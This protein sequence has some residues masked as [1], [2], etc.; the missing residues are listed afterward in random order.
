[1]R[2]A[3]LLP[4]LSLGLQAQPDALRYR[5]TGPANH[6]LNFT[7]SVRRSRPVELD[8]TL[9]TAG[10][11]VP[12]AV[13]DDARLG[14][15]VNRIE[16]QPDARVWHGTVENE[17]ASEVIIVSY[18][19]AISGHILRGEGRT[20]ELITLD[21]TL[22]LRE[23]APRES[24]AIDDAI[25]LSANL[26]RHEADSCAPNCDDGFVVDVLVAYSEQLRVIRGGKDQT[27]ALVREAIAQTNAAFERS[28][29]QT[30]LRLVHSLEVQFQ[31]SQNLF[32][33][34]ARLQNPADGFL[35]ELHALRRHYGAD[36]VSLWSAIGDSSAGVAYLG[37]NT[38]SAADWAFSVVAGQYAVS[39]LTFAHEIGHNFGA[40]HDHLNATS[41]PFVD[42]AYGYQGPRIASPYRTIMAYA[43]TGYTCDR[44][45][46]F[47]NLTAKYQNQPIGD[48]GA[49]NAR[50]FNQTRFALARYLPTVEAPARTI[51]VTPQ[52]TEIPASG[53]AAVIT[54]S[55]DGDWKA[56]S[57]LPWV[58]A[59]PAV[60]TGNGRVLLTVAANTAAASR[61]GVVVIGPYLVTV[62]QAGSPTAA[63]PTLPLAADTPTPGVLM[64]CGTTPY[65][66]YTFQGVAGQQ[67]AV[68][69]TSTEFDPSLSISGPPGYRG[70]IANSSYFG[71]NDDY[72]GGT[73]SR[74]PES[75]NF[76]GLPVS[77]AYT[78]I[79]VAAGTTNRGRFTVTV[80]SS[81]EYCRYS[82]PSALR[83]SAGAS[84]FAISVGAAT[85]CG[86]NLTS[87]TGWLNVTLPDDRHGPASVTLRVEPNPEAAARAAELLLT[88]GVLT[89][90]IRI[91][92]TQAAGTPCAAED[93][94][95]DVAVD[96]TIG[97]GACAS[98]NRGPSYPSKRYSVL[99]KAGQRL[100]FAVKSGDFEPYLALITASGALIA[101]S[102]QGRLGSE[103]APLRLP[104][105]GLYYLEVSGF[106]PGATGR[107]TVETN[108]KLP[109]PLVD[110]APL[111]FNLPNA[112]DLPAVT[113]GTLLEDR[114][115]EFEV[116]ANATRLQLSATVTPAAQVGLHL[117]GNEPPVL[118]DGQITADATVNAD[119]TGAIALALS[120]DTVPPLRAGKYYLALSQ[121]TLETPV[122]VSITA[123]INTARVTSFQLVDQIMT[124]TPTAACTLQTSRSDSFRTTDRLAAFVFTGVA[125]MGGVARIQ[126]VDP[127]GVERSAVGL[128][129]AAADGD[130]CGQAS[131]MIPGANAGAPGR[132][133]VRLVWDGQEVFSRTFVLSE[134]A[135]TLPP[136]LTLGQAQALTLD[137]VAIPLLL[138]RAAVYRVTAPAGVSRLV[139]RLATQTAAADLDLYVRAGV[140]P[141]SNGARIVADFV[142]EG[143]TGDETITIDR[144]LAVPKLEDGTVY[145]ITIAQRTTGIPIRATLT[146][147]ASTDPVSVTRAVTTFGLTCLASAIEYTEFNPPASAATQGYPISLHVTGNARKDTVFSFEF[148]TP[149]GQKVQQQTLPIHGFDG[150]FCAAGIVDLQKVSPSQ[151]PGKW[152]AQFYVNNALALTRT[153]TILGAAPA[154]VPFPKDQGVS[155]SFDRPRVGL[156]PTQF[157]LTVPEG[158]R[159]LTLDLQSKS[160][161]GGTR[162]NLDLY[163]Q[164]GGPVTNL[165]QVSASAATDSPHEKLT[166]ISPAAGEYYVG[167]TGPA[168]TQTLMMSILPTFVGPTGA[169]ASA[170]PISA[171]SID[172][173]WPAKLP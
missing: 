116:P 74:F 22:F 23:L 49:D 96:S 16:D 150:Y 129:A 62:N 61:R 136:A 99:G 63:C 48:G 81:P 165:L 98:L 172:D 156:Y 12:F 85:G 108:T 24:A 40:Q 144:A 127:T 18:G 32:V 21:G 51:T 25:G 84:A 28:G 105:D 92:V 82:V 29:V 95:M 42:Y 138:N 60:G 132:W 113:E 35:D 47:S 43:C 10:R 134:T 131:L 59:A 52:A 71:G 15:R 3:I 126:F 38:A 157:R 149:G 66:F 93:L 169:P 91:P 11:R 4:L 139:F 13:F 120:A 56:F 72:A 88:S 36:L 67:I 164:K 87:S 125:Q 112:L 109:P 73:N 76:V 100:T 167:I 78:I 173:V 146:A 41:R 55:A 39:N 145:Y 94:A 50:A 155:F 46:Y 6:P 30:R 8:V 33:D 171:E 53:G 103:N 166:L 89:A 170:R 114:L 102:D 58:T 7:A 79:V 65:V 122:S 110:A 31:A 158:T 37:D 135:V 160:S 1:M 14:I 83:F 147:T 141:S 162:A 133:K 69:L 130:Y 143:A 86:W 68:E 97:A 119:E 54:V 123:S 148:V 77:G 159:Q 17:E 121:S 101:S 26:S 106:D 142:S 70:P 151:W 117:R 75:G 27:E 124:T 107:F 20:L 154:V 9:L 5:T 80:R 45:P 64:P 44:I 118:S 152:Q 137:A 168:T 111:L 128:P 115:F 19:T 2:F 163:V 57:A 90:P 34:I 153:F 161:I 140:P 104:A